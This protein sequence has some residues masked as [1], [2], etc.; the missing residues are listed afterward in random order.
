MFKNIEKE[1]YSC[2]HII[3]IIILRRLKC[4]IY[5]NS[6]IGIKN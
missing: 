1:G 6:Q 4:Y 3:I 5:E 2:F